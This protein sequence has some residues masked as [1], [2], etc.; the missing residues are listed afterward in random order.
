MHTEIACSA[1]RNRKRLELRYDGYSR[2]VEVHTVGTTTA[3]NLAMSVWQVRGGSSS[4]ER[5][6]W[7]LMRLDEARSAHEI[8]EA[9]EA[10][11]RGYKRNAQPLSAIRDQ[12]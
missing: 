9:S 8:D 12:V 1:L 3:G 11:R 2:V 10:P 7:K 6:G 5:T 4:N